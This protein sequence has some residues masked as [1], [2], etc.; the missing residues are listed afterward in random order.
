MAGAMTKQAIFATSLLAFMAESEGTALSEICEKLTQTGGETATFNRLTESTAV[1]GVASMFGSGS[2]T[3]GDMKEFKA[4]IDYFSA[5]Q[6]I[7]KA[8]MNK[9]KIDI[10]NGYVR[11][12]G[13]AVDRKKD[14]VILTAIQAEDAKLRKLGVATET[15]DA[16]AKL[17]IGAITTAVA[18]AEITPDGKQGVVLAMNKKDWGALSTSDYVLNSDYAKTFAGSANGMNGF[19]GAKLLFIDFIPSGTQYV[20]P[21]NTNGFA[22]WEASNDAT[23]E[24]HATDGMTY[25]AQ[26]VKSGGAVCIE[27]DAITKFTSK[28]VAAAK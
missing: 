11:S 28:P 5:Q 17:L 4:K 21:S 10:R 24:Y 7:K 3:G 25:H 9:T 15:I 12:L 8:D 13:N 20:I 26:A 19:F 18:S 16:Q 14:I 22:E 1:D 27:P 2:D 23:C 6:K